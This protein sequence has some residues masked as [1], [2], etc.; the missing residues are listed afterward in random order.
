MGEKSGSDLI[1]EERERQKEVEGWT[2]E[3]DDEHTDGSL[4]LAA[5]CYAQAGGCG[6]IDGASAVPENWP[7]SWDENWWKPRPAAGGL[8]EIDD[9]IDMLKKTGALAAADIDRLLRLKAREIKSDA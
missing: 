1:A 5:A 9:A 3:H 2:P 7:K 4:A 8:V 6:W